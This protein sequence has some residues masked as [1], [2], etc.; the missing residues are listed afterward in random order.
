MYYAY[1]Y[2]N[3]NSLNSNRSPA[4]KLNLSQR[5]KNMFC[6]I[7]FLELC[8][9]FEIATFTMIFKKNPQITNK[10][11]FSIN[12]NAQTLRGDKSC[13]KKSYSKKILIVDHDIQIMKPQTFIDQIKKKDVTYY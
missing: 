13:Y 7:D 2:F 3:Y 9:D 1:M 4:F 8:L 11:V 12:F 10:S 6:R 5:Y